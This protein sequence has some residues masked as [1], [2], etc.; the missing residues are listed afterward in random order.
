M[1]VSFVQS[2]L[3]NLSGQEE[4]KEHLSADTVPALKGGLIEEKVLYKHVCH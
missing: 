1:H 4:S 2:G 3:A